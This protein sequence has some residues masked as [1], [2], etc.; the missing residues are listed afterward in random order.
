MTGTRFGV[1]I[2]NSCLRSTQLSFSIE[3]HDAVLYASGSHCWHQEVG[4]DLVGFMITFPVCIYCNS[5]CHVI[6]YMYIVGFFR[7]IFGVV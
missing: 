2:Y 1:H 6:G 3:I 5:V 7:G 4:S